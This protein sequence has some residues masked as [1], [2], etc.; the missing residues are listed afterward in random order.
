MPTQAA[1]S[2][3][4]QEPVI[5]RATTAS[6][7]ADL[8]RSLDLNDAAVT[9]IWLQRIWRNPAFRDALRAATP[10]LA[11]AVEAVLEGRRKDA[12]QV[13]RTALSATSYL[14]RWHHRPTPLGLLAGTA[15][16]STGGS[17]GAQWG[18]KHQVRLHADA[19]WLTD[20]ILA[21]Q[22]EP[23]LLR[24][25]PLVA[26][27]TARERGTRLVAM[28]PPADAY[29]PFLAPV[30]V[31][32]RNA[33]P[34]AAATKAARN[35]IVYSD[36]HS[37]LTTLFPNA[38]G[39]QIDTLLQGLISHHLL[40]T[41]LWAP[42]T[43]V[44][45]FGHLC[46][47]L[48]RVSAET[49]PGLHDLVTALY[50][51]RDDLAAH[52]PTAS[53]IALDVIAPKMRAL[54]AA[55]TTPLVIDTEL[56]CRTEIPAA[57]LE[58]AQAAVTALYR[59]TPHPYGYQHWRD[60][61]RRFRARYGVGALVPVM[62]LVSDSGLGLPAGFLGSERGRPPR[63]LTERD[64]VLLALLQS[65]F[66]EGRNELVL[67]DQLIDVLTKA[68]GT[69]PR[70]ANR[71]ETAFEIHAPSTAALDR[72]GFRIVLTSAPRPGSS[73][74]GR[75]AHLLPPDECKGLAA[76][77]LTDPGAITAQLSFPPRK[78]RNENV[79]RTPRLLP[80]IITLGEH[81][82]ADDQTIPLA[83]IAVTADAHRFHLVQQSTERRLDVRVLHALEAGAQ[84]PAVARFIAEVA[85]ARH[86]AYKPFDFG[87]ATRLPYLP[88]VRYRRTVL[89]PARWLLTAD[90][91]P[92]QAA[93]QSTWDR[94]FEAWR[95]RTR[96]PDAVALLELDQRLPL[97][98]THPVHRRLLRASLERD[99]HL[100]LREAPPADAFG[101]IGR[102]HEVW[103]SLHR[104]KP[105]HALEEVPRV[106]VPRRAEPPRPP[107][108]EAQPVLYA[109]LRAHP[110]RYDEIL[111][112]HLAEL[113]AAISDPEPL[114]WFSRHREVARPDADQYLDLVLH[115]APGTYG[116][117]A[118]HVRTWADALHRSGLA[119]GLTLADYQ[120]QTGRFGHGDAM[121]AAH[122]VFAADSAA[123][124][125]QIRSADQATDAIAPQA[126]AAASVFDLITHLAPT[127]DEGIDWLI[128]Q[129][130]QATGRLDPQLRE[131][132]LRFTHPSS[133]SAPADLP[134][135]DAV[136]PSWQARAAALDNYRRALTG[137]DPLN[138]ARSL[139]HQHH[140]RAL[141]ADPAAEA[142][143][144]RL[145]RAAGLRERGGVR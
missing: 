19:E 15:T 8:P 113:L 104:T 142:V 128:R 48:K 121:D 42:M 69:E 134:G 56:D 3:R 71:I 143:T 95:A 144:L 99:Q 59:T 12:R 35:P 76:G 51:L 24:R 123:A 17:A 50:D 54:S 29:A 141:G 110:G 40:V 66:V 47:E 41:S 14:L 60:Y 78:R 106:L 7:P 10:G 44:D 5:L 136:A 109:R 63:Q 81:H 77:Y 133:P 6:G 36:L 107:F 38:A 91:L 82:P 125:A 86:A 30:E 31:S 137:Y 92:G 70:F 34:V 74:A 124:L 93:G 120:P 72:G 49:I 130:P 138:A 58:E 101:W 112:L 55:T 96:V 89:A 145:V 135:R 61:H 21:L 2:Y 98:L 23:D 100:E 57:V 88:R 43:T 97:D 67:T 11:Q 27:N 80:H 90:S 122:Q 83:D 52:P 4:W 13:R 102:A 45:A 28:G 26:N 79:I 108:P 37:H 65:V 94:A 126:L 84:T 22:A 16:V 140:V 132:V 139:I 131:Q 53:S 68:A 1:V 116:A 39:S 33:R 25:L 87:A 75:F 129:L 64:E 18:E 46:A 62:E 73:M 114:W 85:G 105:E 20:V 117:A 111:T 118:E 9:R 127:R 119:A 32:V 115:L 103:I